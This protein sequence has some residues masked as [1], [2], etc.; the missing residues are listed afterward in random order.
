VRVNRP[1]HLV[2]EAERLGGKGCFG[3][4]SHRAILG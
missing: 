4:G 1:D 3:I 2:R